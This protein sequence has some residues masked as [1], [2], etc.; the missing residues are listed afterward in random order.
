VKY[1]KE[2]YPKHLPQQI[3]DLLEQVQN[4]SKGYDVYVGGGSL[5]DLYVTVNQWGEDNYSMSR[6]FWEPKDIDLFFVPNGEDVRILPVVPK[7]YV[8]YDKKAEDISPDMVARGVSHLR[9]MLVSGLTP[10]HDVQFIVYDKQMSVEELCADMSEN[11]NQVMWSPESGWVCT[12]A[13]VDG[14]LTRTILQTHTYDETRMID[15]LVRM[16]RKFP[17]YDV[18]SNL[19]WEDKYEDVEYVP[20]R[21]GSFCE[22]DS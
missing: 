5:R 22:E 3:K 1:T 20:E 18:V 17:E 10:T 8:N 4:D 7:S 2:I 9:G 15:R 19:D 21:G 12:E 13:F 16:K 6:I 11:I 14:H